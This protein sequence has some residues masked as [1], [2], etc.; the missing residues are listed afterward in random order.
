MA[1]Q[2]LSFFTKKNISL[3]EFSK[4]Y[5]RMI[6]SLNEMSHCYRSPKIDA[7]YDDFNTKAIMPVNATVFYYFFS[8]NRSGKTFA[9]WLLS[10]VRY[11][12]ERMR[13]AY[14]RFFA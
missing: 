10:S 13:R 7:N 12:N 4:E 11:P 8:S 2:H 9:Q 6:D 3:R 5:A 1:S 14:I